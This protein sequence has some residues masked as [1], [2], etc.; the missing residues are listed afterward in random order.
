MAPIFFT[1]LHDAGYV[2]F[3]KEVNYIME[4]RA[5]EY[6]FLKLSTDF[7]IRDTMY[8]YDKN[9]FGKKSKK[10]KRKRNAKTKQKQ[11]TKML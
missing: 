11:L 7:F 6:A 10:K 5:V 8:N 2:I 4:G 3:S 1:R 9:G